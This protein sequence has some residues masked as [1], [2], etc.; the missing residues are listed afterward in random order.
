VPTWSEIESI[1]SDAD[2]LTGPDVDIDARRANG[3]TFPTEVVTAPLSGQ[4]GSVITPRDITERK[5]EEDARMRVL[6]TVAHELRTPLSAVLGA[7]DLL[8]ST[9]P[10]DLKQFHL[11]APHGCHGQRR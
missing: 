1:L 5:T 3:T 9:S 11:Q 8:T 7:K 4:E 2:A 6:Q 10:S